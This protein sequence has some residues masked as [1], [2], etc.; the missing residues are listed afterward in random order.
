MNATCTVSCAYGYTG[1]PVYPVCV[2]NGSAAAWTVPTG[3]AGACSTYYPSAAYVK[4]NCNNRSVG[5]VCD[6]ECSPRY[7][8]VPVDPICTPNLMWTSASGCVGMCR[9]IVIFMV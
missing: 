5:A 2:S 6:L 9:Y 4:V 8:G 1:T 7:T 3:C